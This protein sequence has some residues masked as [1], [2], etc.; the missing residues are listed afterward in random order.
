MLGASKDLN[1]SDINKHTNP[2][3]VVQTTNILII[4][5]R[6]IVWSKVHGIQHTTQINIIAPLLWD[7]RYALTP[8]H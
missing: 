2:S 5:G 3:C 7:M 6:M 4:V 8:K 1:T